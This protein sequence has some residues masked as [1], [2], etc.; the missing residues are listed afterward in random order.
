M[1]G[2]TSGQ[3]FPPKEELE[4]V[5]SSGHTDENHLTYDCF[6][7]VMKHLLVNILKRDES[8]MGGQIIGTHILWKLAFLFAKWGFTL[9]L[10]SNCDVSKELPGMEVAS[11][12]L[13]A[14][15]KS[16]DSTATYLDDCN[17]L[18]AHVLHDPVNKECHKVGKWEPIHMTALPTFAS[19]LLES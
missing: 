18:E 9:H 16:P 3:L 15:H 7:G 10:T 17:T 5:K 6:L 13:S 4:N 12:L 14:R 1:S 8:K 2:I 11:I 19:L